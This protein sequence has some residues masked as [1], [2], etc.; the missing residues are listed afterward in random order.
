MP[1]CIGQPMIMRKVEINDNF[2][3]RIFQF[4]G[5]LSCVTPRHVHTPTRSNKT[6]A[7]ELSTTIYICILTKMKTQFGNNFYFMR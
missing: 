1:A 7:M 4:H 5:L 2:S 3:Q 6:V